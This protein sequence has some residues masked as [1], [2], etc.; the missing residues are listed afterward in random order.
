M[1]KVNLCN[2]FAWVYYD[3]FEVDIWSILRVHGCLHDTSVCTIGG[4]DR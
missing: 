1:F 4:K 3:C 2:I